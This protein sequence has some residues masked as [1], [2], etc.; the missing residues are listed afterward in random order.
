M[1]DAPDIA[2]AYRRGRV[3]FMGLD[4]LTA[5][6]AL[7]PRIETELLANAALDL[8]S[9]MKVQQ[10]RVID[11]CCGAGNLA[12]A[13]ACNVASA[14]IWACDITDECVQLAGRNIA[15]HG[16]ADRVSVHQGD[17][18]SPLQGMSLEGTI[19]AIIC[20][21]PYISEK[22]LDGDRA[23][24]LDREPREAFAA[25]PNGLGIHT[26]VIREALPFLRKEGVL[27]VEVGLGQDRQVELLFKRTRAYQRVDIV[28]NGTGEGR[29]V[30]GQK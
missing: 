26:R 24:L 21:P 18:L 14:R 9:S 19:D 11:L 23:G 16:L 20:N 27:L 25:G 5:Q 3:K 15:F 28:R 22:R 12:C 7:V 8:I 6:G 30:V 10:A 2:D 13:L 29:V 17:L 4:I 1:S